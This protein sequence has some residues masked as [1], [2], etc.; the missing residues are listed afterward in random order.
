MVDKSNLVEWLDDKIAKLNAGYR[1][2]TGEPQ[3]YLKG[4]LASLNELK[5]QIEDGK[6]DKKEDTL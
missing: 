3:A 1:V 6:F 2:R 4:A 5:S